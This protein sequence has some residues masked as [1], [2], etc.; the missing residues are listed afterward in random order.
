MTWSTK[1]HIRQVLALLF[2]VI[3]GSWFT[4]NLLS[5]LLHL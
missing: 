5:L 4:W 1:E 3:A 2:V